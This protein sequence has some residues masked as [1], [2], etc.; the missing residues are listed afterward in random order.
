MGVTLLSGWV[1][2][3][4][5]M[6]SHWLDLGKAWAGNRSVHRLTIW[7]NPGQLTQHPVWTFLVAHDLHIGSSPATPAVRH[8]NIMWKTAWTG[9]RHLNFQVVMSP[10][11]VLEPIPNLYLVCPLGSVLRGKTHLHS[12]H[13][14][15]TARVPGGSHTGSRRLCSHRCHPYKGEGHVHIRQ[16]LK[17]K[18]VRSSEELWGKSI[19]ISSTGEGS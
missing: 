17:G 4:S 7:N 6:N 12:P 8:I 18:N 3:G 10:T 11:Q 19:H 2:L 13:G 16:C 9:C 5:N 15:A 1:N 14:M